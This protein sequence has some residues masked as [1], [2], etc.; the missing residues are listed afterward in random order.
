[1]SKA[2]PTILFVGGGSGG[3]I[4]PNVA[5]LERLDELGIQI[6]A[7]FVVSERE[8]DATVLSKAGLAGAAISAKP[9]SMRPDRFWA[10]YK[11]YK[12]AEEQVLGLIEQT[13]A[14]AVL[15]TGGFVSGPS[16]SAAAKAGIA[17][18]LVSLDAVPGKSN[19]W[20]AR[21]ASALF[22]AYE[23]PQLNRAQLIS[24]PLRRSVIGQRSAL[25]ARLALGLDPNLETLLIFGGSQGGGSINAA[26][27]QLA[28]R[29]K[30]KGMFD[31]W[32]LLHLTGETDRDRVAS[33]YETAGIAHRVE[34]FCAEMGLAWSAA[35]LA[36]C[37]AGAGSVAESWAN[38]V[39]CLFMPY[40]Y[41]KDEHQRQNAAPI[42]N[43]GA[44]LLL[45]DRIDEH[46]NVEELSGPLRDLIR[47]SVRREQMRQVLKDS[48]PPDGAAVLADW[49]LGVTGLAVKPESLLQA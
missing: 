2:S 35:T 11:A 37:R 3:H 23:T 40:P 24:V 29:A 18:A 14:K 20:S 15:A 19:R 36:V 27:A 17:R 4:Y 9:L 44:G 13:G 26:F 1:M 10:F 28:S 12:L 42:V 25:Q 43:R 31:G 39:P 33:A 48:H 7:H 38:A 46:D 21:K 32:Q 6:N 47:N 16:I 34:A 5:V 8:I 49:L 30:S 41:H 22:S 45:K